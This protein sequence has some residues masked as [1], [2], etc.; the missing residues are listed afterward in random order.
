[1]FFSEF[2]INS[3][4]FILYDQDGN[5]IID[6]DFLTEA[7]PNVQNIGTQQIPQQQDPN[8]D[9][10]GIVQQPQ[11]NPTS[12]FETIKSYVLFSRFKELRQFVQDVNMNLQNPELDSIIEFLDMILLFYTSFTYSDLSSFIDSITTSLEE[13]LKIKLPKRVFSDPD[14]D[15]KAN[16]GM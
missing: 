11:M 16:V 9:P 5:N 12:E 3:N 8:I 10:Y 4:E 13:K 6:F 14:L 1:M 15:P 2:L 7:Q